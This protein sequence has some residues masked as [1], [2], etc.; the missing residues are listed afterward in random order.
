V[1]TFQALGVTLVAIL[2]GASYTFAY[3]RVAGGF[4]VSLADRLFRFL[5]ASAV[6]AALFFGPGLVVY[7]DYVVTGRLAR[8][9]LPVGAAWAIVVVYVALPTGV[10][11]ALGAA[12]L[13]DKGWARVLL[14]G[15][16]EPRAWD[17]LWRMRK[18]GVVRMR[19]MSGTWLA[20]FYGTWS[21]RQSYAAGYPE[22]GDLYLAVQLK[23]D[24]ESGK[25][26]RD[27]D[28]RAVPVEGGGGL[29]V[30]WAQVEFLEFQ[31]MSND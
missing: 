4:G 5:A 19:L 25:F 8:G 14:G 13:A 10:G 24:A 6:F 3:E 1:D 11:S 21:E 12:H 7:R 9:E 16:P 31:E 30:R 20:G 22:A 17:H 26:E 23:V 27:A 29:L 15:S 2:P 18:Q 28:G